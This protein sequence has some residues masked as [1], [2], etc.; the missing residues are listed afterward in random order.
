LDKK[1]GSYRERRLEDLLVRTLKTRPL[2]YLNGPRQVGKSTLAERIS[3]Y[4]EARFVSLDSPLASASAQSDPVGFVKSLPADRLNIIDEVQMVPEVFRQI[5]AAV[6]ESRRS[7]GGTGLYLLTGSADV[8]ALPRLAEALVGRMSILTLLPFSA[9]EYRGT[10]R[11]FIESLWS[12][13]LSYRKYGNAGLADVISDATYPE[14]ALNHEINRVQWFDDYLTTILQRDVKTL[15]DIRSPSNIVQLLV[16]LAQR[17]GSLLNNASVMKETGLDAKTCA[18]YKGLLHNTFLTFEVEPWTKPNRLGKRF[19]KQS[20]LYFSDTNLLCHVMR[21]SLPEVLKNDPPAAGHV[22]ENFIAAEIM[23]NVKAATGFRVS[24]FNPSGGREVDFVIENADGEAVG[25]EVKLGESLSDGDFSNMRTLRETL[26]ER[27][28]KGIVIY[29]GNEL[30]L[31]RDG[32]WA[33]PV[34]YLWE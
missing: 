4:G 1:S 15:A 33:V 11:N 6:D 9:A 31:F 22:F 18:K 16:S 23:K 17:A 13:S 2:V 5:K 26:G 7:G 24:H 20:K 10:G 19:V 29:T 3:A 21:R 34:N 8:M 27:F 30:A 28:K 32:M 14:I 25:V 12:G